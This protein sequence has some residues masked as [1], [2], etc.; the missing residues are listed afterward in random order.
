[1][2]QKSFGILSLSGARVASSAFGVAARARPAARPL[3]TPSCKHLSRSKLS[4]QHE[5]VR[6]A[7]S[8]LLH[9]TASAL[10]TRSRASRSGQHLRM[11]AGAST[12][13]APCS[14]PAGDN[15]ATLLTKTSDRVFPVMLPP[16][17]CVTLLDSSN[18]VATSSPA[19]F[20]L[21]GDAVI[22]V[23]GVQIHSA[24]QART[25]MQKR[26]GSTV[27]VHLLVR[28]KA[29]AEATITRAEATTPFGVTFRSVVGSNEVTVLTL[30]PDG[31]MAATGRVAV[32][33]TLM[34]LNDEP[35]TTAQ[36][37]TTALK[38]VPAGGSIKVKVR[39]VPRL[40][41]YLASTNAASDES[42]AT[43]QSQPDSTEV[44]KS[45]PYDWAR[46]DQEEFFV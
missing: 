22:Y 27:P 8:S 35:M 19:G 32:G 3:Q 34:S 4:D 7:V 16:P 21:Q 44:Q 43:G 6:L 23:G 10:E 24:V 11:G 29:E 30:E 40:P 18:E 38:A 2:A 1:M 26:A 46:C 9:P 15:A 37:A 28:R 17:S 33:A 45:F 36:Q 13:C 20:L 14:T 41:G 31:I 5:N 39:Y 25:L 12:S 42:V